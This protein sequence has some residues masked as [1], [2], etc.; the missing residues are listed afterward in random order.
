MAPPASPHLL[1]HQDSLEGMLDFS[2]PPLPDGDHVNAERRFYQII[3]HFGSEDHGRGPGQDTY[4]RIKLVSLTYKY[5][6][7]KICKGR[8]LVAF[9][10][11][12]G[13]PI[14]SGEA[15][16]INFDDPT[17][18]D[19]LRTS[20][21]NF[22]DL[23][24]NNFFLPLKAS[25]GKTPQPTPAC[26]TAIMQTQPDHTFTGTTDR[27]SNL[28]GTCLIRDRYRCVISN[29]FD[30]IEAIKRFESEG[31]G[32]GVA[33]D[34][35]GQPLKGQPFE[36][37]EVAHILP[38]SLTQVDSDGKLNDSKQIALKILNMFDH[39]A[40]HL[41]DGVKIDRPR[42]ALTLT[43]GL[44]THFGSFKIFFQPDSTVLHQ[45]HIGTF[46]PPAVLNDF[47]ITRTLT[48]NSN[49]D[50]PSPQLLTIH[51]A[52]AHI[53]QLSGA[54][55]YIDR[56]LRD[57]DE[58]GIRHD[59]STELYCLIGLRLNNWVGRQVDRDMAMV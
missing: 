19:K 27:I 33:C 26:Y 22:A 37:L 17:H 5:S 36:Q 14:T 7:N 40:A 23:L 25:I 47:P 34:Q 57:A 46:L 54:G 8:I 29:K 58:Y 20:L 52:I 42:N 4:D 31:H 55:D 3:D 48:E 12:A 41:I 44:H 24:F 53:L 30:E 18:R 2:P 13:L 35:D 28:R 15:E 6:T 9:F 49:I 51:C 56:L 11:L 39:R 21:D 32:Q 38:H 50:L 43:R 10:T 45:Y 1:R 16:D 59:G